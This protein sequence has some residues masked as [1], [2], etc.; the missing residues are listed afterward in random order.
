MP[1]ITVPSA[2]VS[3]EQGCEVIS[4]RAINAFGSARRPTRVLSNARE[5]LG[6]HDLD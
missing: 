3:G 4:R 1:T 5:K 2:E 6:G